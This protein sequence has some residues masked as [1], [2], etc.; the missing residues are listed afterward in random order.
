LLFHIPSSIKKNPFLGEA[1]LMAVSAESASLSIQFAA[2]NLS[3]GAHLQMPA[4]SA[5]LTLPKR[6]NA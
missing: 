5:Y 2:F 4:H 3:D 6:D 1:D